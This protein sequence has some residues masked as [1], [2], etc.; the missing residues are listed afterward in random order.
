MTATVTDLLARSD[1]AGDCLR[2]T[3]WKNDDGYGYVHHD[4][5]DQPVHRVVYM[6]A[7]GPIPD[8]HEID[9]SCRRRDCVRP[10]HLEAVTHAENQRR[11][12][13]RQT[14]CRRAGHDWSDP[15]NVRTRRNGRRYCAECDR[16]DQ[17]ARYSNRRAS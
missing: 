11:I 8:G 12:A 10:D 6:L 17:R 3:G 14:A 2:W 4:G 16:I 7:V 15:R 1:A 5:R 9:H 13:E